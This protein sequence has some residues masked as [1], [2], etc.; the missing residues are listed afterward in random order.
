MTGKLAEGPLKEFIIPELEKVENLEFEVIAI[1]NHFYGP[2]IQGNELSTGSGAH[3]CNQH[4]HG[5]L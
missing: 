1:T 3:G 2:A 5:E 4:V